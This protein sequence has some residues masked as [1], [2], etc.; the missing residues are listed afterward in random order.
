MKSVT[1]PKPPS[2]VQTTTFLRPSFAMNVNGTQMAVVVTAAPQP[3]LAN[4]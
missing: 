3:K 4:A 2:T 1:L